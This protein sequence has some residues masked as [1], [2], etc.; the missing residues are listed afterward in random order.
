MILW[1]YLT[2]WSLRF[3]ILLAQIYCPA[4][5][6]TSKGELE[7][8]N[9]KARLKLNYSVMCNKHCTV[10]HEEV[11]QRTLCK[12]IHYRPK[13]KTLRMPSA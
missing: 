7:Q 1:T 4:V 3:G 2:S 5:A 12:S 10:H 6:W 9:L 8:H 11:R 13:Y